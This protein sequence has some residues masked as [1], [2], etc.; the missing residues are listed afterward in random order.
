MIFLKGGIWTASAVHT[1]VMR[2]LLSFLLGILS[3]LLY[4]FVCFALF[5]DR[6]VTF[7]W[8]APLR[9]RTGGVIHALARSRAAS[10]ALIFIP[11]FLLPFSLLTQKGVLILAGD[12]PLGFVQDADMLSGTVQV[13][14]VTPEQEA[15][16]LLR[17]EDTVTLTAELPRFA[18]APVQ[19]GTRAGTLTAVGPAGQNVTVALCYRDPVALDPD[20]KITPLARLGRLWTRVSRYFSAYYPEF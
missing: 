17:P 16:L 9:R 14:A 2:N 7:V 18:F 12:R 10:A 3:D 4:V 15:Y 1:A 13:C 5:L 8:D 19:Q 11:C 6:A 20:V